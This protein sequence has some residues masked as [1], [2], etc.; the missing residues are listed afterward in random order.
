MCRFLTVAFAS[1]P[2]QHPEDF[3]RGR[4][5][6]DLFP[7]SNPTVQAHLA[8]TESYF[9]AM[10]RHCDC[11]SPIGSAAGEEAKYEHLLNEAQRHRRK[12]WSEPKVQRWLAGKHE[13]LDRKRRPSGEEVESFRLF[14]SDA[15]SAGASGV[16]MLLHMYP[17]DLEAPF[18]FE[19][20]NVEADAV[21]DDW[22]L[23]MREDVL[24][25]IQPPR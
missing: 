8:P 12:G 25:R 24:Y 1:R 9:R 2:G 17:A 20:E 10:S 19:S 13:A 11:D 3:T 4:P 15:A 18:T 22:L 16:A 5:P 14:L 23:R 21:T 7:V 6:L